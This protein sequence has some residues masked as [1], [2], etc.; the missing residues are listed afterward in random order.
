MGFKPI[1]KTNNNK[2]FPSIAA[3][4]W[5]NHICKI[6]KKKRYTKYKIDTKPYLAFGSSK[7]LYLKLSYVLKSTES[8]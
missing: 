4:A 2:H 5:K 1:F 3:I 6:K 8:L 7:L